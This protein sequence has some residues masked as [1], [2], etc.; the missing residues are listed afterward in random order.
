[1]LIAKITAPPATMA[2]LGELLNMTFDMQDLFAKITL[3]VHVKSI[4][5]P[6]DP[7]EFAKCSR[8]SIQ[9]L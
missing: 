9:N 2:A 4:L 1:M 3:I 7:R 6:A 8:L 5:S